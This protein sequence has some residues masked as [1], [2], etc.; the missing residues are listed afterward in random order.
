MLPANAVY[1]FAYIVQEDQDCS[2]RECKKDETYFFGKNSKFTF[3]IMKHAKI[4]KLI[5]NY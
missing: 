4:V 1:Y 2:K 3:A 5:F